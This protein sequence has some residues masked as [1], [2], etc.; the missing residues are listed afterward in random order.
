[1]KTL[2]AGLAAHVASPA[3]TLATCWTLTRRDGVRLGFTDHDRPITLDGVVHEAASGLGSSEDVAAAGL[4]VGGAEVSGA[5]AS[6]AIAEADIAAGLYDGARVTVTRVD[7]R[8]PAEHVVLRIATIGEI[9]ERDGAFR[10]ELR[11]LA[12]ELDQPRGRLYGHRCD[13][14]LGDA[15]CGIDLAAAGWRGTGTVVAASSLRSLTASGLAAFAAGLFDRG[16][17]VFTGGA[18]AG[19]AVEVKFHDLAA[20]LARFELWQPMAAPIAA[21]DGFTVTAGCDKRF[22]TCR[23]RFGNALNFRGFPHIPGNDFVLAHPGRSRLPNDGK[24]LVR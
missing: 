22:A 14:A 24:A 1:M 17:L 23:D 11:G 18:N 8:D 9:V 13:A 19:R 2:S 4:S 12:A 6:A 3:T 16:R 10:A 21:G 20:G 5:L 15:R 7:W